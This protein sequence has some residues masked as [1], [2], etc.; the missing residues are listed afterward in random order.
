MATS[1]CANAELDYR[2]KSGPSRVGTEHVTRQRHTV[3]CTTVMWRTLTLGEAAYVMADSA[4]L[5]VLYCIVLYCIV[6][7]CIALHCIAVQQS[8]VL[9]WLD[10]G[11]GASV[12]PG[13]FEPITPR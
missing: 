11:A 5:I 8:A 2:S 4:A 7:H 6:L 1:A 12:R 3:C 10:R 13:A 9:E